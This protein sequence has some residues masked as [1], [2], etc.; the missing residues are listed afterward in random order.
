MVSPD[1][2]LVSGNNHSWDQTESHSGCRSRTLSVLPPRNRINPTEK[3]DWESKPNFSLGS[4]TP[5]LDQHCEFPHSLPIAYTSAKSVELK[6]SRHPQQMQ[7]D[8]PG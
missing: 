8:R 2:S 1:C 6:G 4:T 7:L 3:P 5:F